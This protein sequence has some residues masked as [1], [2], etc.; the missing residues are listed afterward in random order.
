LVNPDSD[1]GKHPFPGR[2]RFADMDIDGHPDLLISLE[3]EEKPD[4]QD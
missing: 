2:I 1:Q 4:G 3:F